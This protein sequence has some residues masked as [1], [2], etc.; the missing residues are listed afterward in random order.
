VHVFRCKNLAN[1]IFVRRALADEIDRA[2]FTG[3]RWREL[4]DVS[5]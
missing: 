4:A 3:A 5:L 1:F 2:G